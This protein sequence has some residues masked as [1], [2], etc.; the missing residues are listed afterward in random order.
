LQVS[1]AQADHFNQ[2]KE[3]M[4]LA[5]QYFDSEKAANHWLRSFNITLNSSPLK[6]CNTS[7]G[8]THVKNTIYKLM[9]GLTA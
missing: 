1:P 7:E 6:L 4:N 5:V 2:L 8:V 9:H 3:L